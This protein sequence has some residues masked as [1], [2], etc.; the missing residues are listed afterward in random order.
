[1]K[2]LLLVSSLVSLAISPN[3]WAEKI[4]GPYSCDHRLTITE[5]V[6]CVNKHLFELQTQMGKLTMENQNQLKQIAELEKENQRLRELATLPEKYQ[7]VRAFLTKNDADKACPEG[8]K[9]AHVPLLFRG[10]T[11]HEICAANGREE[12]SCH[13]VIYH[14][15]RNNNTHGIYSKHNKSCQQPVERPWPW[16][17]QYSSPNTLSS[18]WGHGDTWVVCCKR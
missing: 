13:S 3:V 11:G 18:E 15:V 14:F 2:K 17:Y 7:N 6:D 5:W 4:G 12:K 10:K 16:S 8:S 9:A 1:M